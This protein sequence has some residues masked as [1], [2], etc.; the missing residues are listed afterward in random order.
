MP[1]ISAT[2]D[3][4]QSLI[5]LGK[6]VRARRAQQAF[7]QEALA[8]AAGIDRSHMG[9]IERGER[10]VTFLNIARIAHALGC[11]PSD[12]LLDADL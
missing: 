4:D 3:Q 2:Q 9:K 1:R 12:L 8:D 11:K 5:R 10:N 6:A 7:S